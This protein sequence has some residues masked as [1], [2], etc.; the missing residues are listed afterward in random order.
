[1]ADGGFDGEAAVGGGRDGRRVR[2]W[3]SLWI[4]PGE[5]L[6]QLFRSRLCHGR[7]E[8]EAEFFATCLQLREDR[9]DEV[10][11]GWELVMNAGSAEIRIQGWRY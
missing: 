11:H 1:M 7:A 10:A 8:S 2:L 5:S 3:A 6:L 4:H 9:F